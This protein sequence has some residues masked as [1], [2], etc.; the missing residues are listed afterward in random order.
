MAVAAEGWVLGMA[1]LQLVGVDG[2]GEANSSILLFKE[3]FS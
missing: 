1:C 2:E 3:Y